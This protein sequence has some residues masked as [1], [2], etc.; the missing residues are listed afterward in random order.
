MLFSF[1]QTVSAGVSYEG[2]GRMHF[3]DEKAKVN[4]NYYLQNLLPKLFND[5]HTVLGNQFIFKQLRWSV[6]SRCKDGP[7]LVNKSLS[8]LHQQGFMAAKFSRY[9]PTRL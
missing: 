8:E 3:I 1:Q 6:C 5:S 2:K 7:R 4:A 9:E